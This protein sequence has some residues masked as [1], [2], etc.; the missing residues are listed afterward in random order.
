M[1]K[2]ILKRKIRQLKR[3]KFVLKENKTRQKTKL[4]TTEQNYNKENK[5]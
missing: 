5:Y 4:E 1:L 3:H 2:T